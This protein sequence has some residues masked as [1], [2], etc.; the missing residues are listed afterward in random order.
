MALVGDVSFEL[1]SSLD[2]D[3]VL[4]STARRLSAISGAPLCDIYTLRDGSQLESVTSIDE[5]EV[6]REWQG[7]MFMLD[8]WT[9]MRKAVESREPVL[10][11]SRDDPDLSPAEIPLMEEFGENGALMCR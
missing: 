10:V 7:R 9:A 5:G 3:E 11:K 8:D 4:L 6:D 1:T 2:L